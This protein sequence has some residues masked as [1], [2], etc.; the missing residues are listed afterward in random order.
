M[1]GLFRRYLCH[2]NRNRRPRGTITRFQLPHLGSDCRVGSSGVKMELAEV[3]KAH[4]I[5]ERHRRSHQIIRACTRKWSVN[6]RFTPKSGHGRLILIKVPLDARLYCWSWRGAKVETSYDKVDRLCLCFDVGVTGTG[7]AT[8]TPPSAQRDCHPSA[9]S[10]WGGYAHGERYLHK[11]SCPPSSQP[12]C[13]RS[14]LLVGPF[15]R[16]YRTPTASGFGGTVIMNVRFLPYGRK[17]AA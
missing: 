14:D 3:P 1:Y 7:Y 10:M 16:R 11:N 4:P 2:G 6:V 12:V 17:I 9:R 13:A 8:H 15:E 5:I